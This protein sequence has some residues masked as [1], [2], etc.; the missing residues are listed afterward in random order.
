MAAWRTCKPRCH[1]GGRRR[2]DHYKGAKGKQCPLSSL[3]GTGPT[4]P[5]HQ[6]RTLPSPRLRFIAAT[7]LM[8][9][10]GTCQARPT[11]TYE[12]ENLR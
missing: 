3:E 1:N 8:R 10:A 7:R 6:A 2:D 9:L 5:E 4:A 12:I 11:F